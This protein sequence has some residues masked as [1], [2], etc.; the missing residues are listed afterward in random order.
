MKTLVATTLAFAVVLGL[1]APA[2]AQPTPPPGTEVHAQF[3]GP[4]ADCPF[5][6]P[7]TVVVDGD[8][9]DPS[10]YSV[11]E[12]DFRPFL[13]LVDIFVSDLPDGAQVLSV[14]CNAGTNP[15]AGTSIAPF[16]SNCALDGFDPDNGLGNYTPEFF[17]LKIFSVSADALAGIQPFTGWS[18]SDGGSSLD[19]ASATTLAGDGSVFEAPTF[20]RSSAVSIDGGSAP[21][22]ALQLV[23]VGAGVAVMSLFLV[24]RRQ[25]Q[26]V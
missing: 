5:G 10:A 11:V 16:T 12:T 7:V 17:C 14:I 18:W 1:T 23:A 21:W 8:A 15:V 20:T 26:L 2:S 22:L 13:F 9:L 24:R 19:A 3:W 4:V 6:S 25:R